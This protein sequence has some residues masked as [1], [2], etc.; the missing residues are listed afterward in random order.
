MSATS[1]KVGVAHFSVRAVLVEHSYFSILM[2]KP[3]GN[4][5]SKTDFPEQ[6]TQFPVLDIC[7]KEGRILE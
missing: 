2:I 4:P 1:R 5:L 6:K 3:Q 7:R